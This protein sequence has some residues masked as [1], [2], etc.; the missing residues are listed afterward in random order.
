MYAKSVKIVG[1]VPKIKDGIQT[2]YKTYHCTADVGG[3]GVGTATY[4]FTSRADYKLGATA[5]IV[6]SEK[7]LANGERFRCWEAVNF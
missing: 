7:T 6:Y 1:I 4:T 5:Y 2:G 3:N